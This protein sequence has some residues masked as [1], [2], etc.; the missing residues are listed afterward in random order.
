M[1]K[2]MIGF[3]I[4]LGLVL[5]L[6]I[7]LPF[8]VNIKDI[9]AAQ[10]PAIEKQLHR[11]ISIGDVKLTLLTGVGAEIKNVSISN[12]P[13][14]RKEAFVSMESLQ[15]KV[16]LLPLLKKTVTISSI[17]IRKPDILIEKDAGGRM[18]F[19][20]MITPKETP[21]P[22]QAE[23]GTK[24]PPKDPLA[25]L[26]TFQVSNLSIKDARFRFFDASHP[27][28]AKEYALDR[29]NLSLDAAYSPQE[30][31]LDL[32][33][34]VTV[35]VSDVFPKDSG[36]PLSIRCTTVLG[37]DS[38]QIEQLK[39]VLGEMAFTAAAQIQNF[40]APRIE[41]KMSLEP[42]SL[43]ALAKI[44]PVLKPFDLKGKL[45]L[46]DLRIT[47]TV[48]E[49][50]AL[51]GISGNLTLQNGSVTPAALEKT[52]EKIQVSAALAG[53]DV[54]IQEI[55]FQ[56][57]PSDIRID[58]V[59]QN[60]L[61]PAVSFQLAS[62]NLDIDALLP[63]PSKTQPVEG[64]KEPTQ[65]PDTKGEASK[66]KKAPDLKVN[67]RV[68]IKKC[69]V[70]HMQLDDVTAELEYV[71]AI[72]L[73]KNLRF[74]AFGGTVATSAR[75]D[76]ADMQ[77][78]KWNIDLS[79]EKINANSALS[80]LSSLKDTLYGDVNTTLSLQGTGKDWPSISKSMD[81]K[82]SASVANGK[83]ASVNLLD[84]VGQSLLHFQ[85]LGLL[86]Q[87][88]SPQGGT[89][90]KE[91][92]FQDLTGKLA[93][94]E[95]KIQVEA[96]KLAA[97][98]FLLSGGGK[99]GLDKSLDLRTAVV[100]SDTLSARLEKDPYLKYLLNQNKQLEIPCAI[101]G[102]IMKPQVA[103]DGDS[104]NRLLQKAATNAAKDQLQQG[105]EQKLGKDAGKL[106][107]GIFK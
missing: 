36:A 29:L 105:V 78:P 82:G 19:A 59:I 46:P 30:I 103:A 81:G 104:L 99:I 3:A 44:L 102:D 15:A 60:I 89:P 106:L 43:D 4:F 87:T 55:S 45:A 73:L 83:F 66:P 11:K 90:L 88:L 63:P 86:A 10:I 13:D 34:D 9:V 84:A 53:K 58:A 57:G 68:A 37:K 95:G 100:L 74:T 22:K 1:K 65:T 85:G 96:L 24:E 25:L 7:I 23:T 61:K 67:G 62:S 75:V 27:G 69:T 70:N 28:T 50:K 98:D 21:E 54:K 94:L 14:F 71:N 42:T 20:D 92:A 2:I 77:T 51:K 107:Q 16:R 8:V 38:I 76:L 6:L 93:I 52:I 97:R 17:S 80:Q 101:K 39:L 56:V 35:I 64:K 79:T 49:L 41:G 48:D 33:T 26:Q 12:H 31:R 32:D 91:T 47:G 40:T 5:C 18:N 72:A